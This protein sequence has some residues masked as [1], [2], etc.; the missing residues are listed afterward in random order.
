MIDAR[1]PVHEAVLIY[2]TFPETG[3][4]NRIGR[5]LVEARLAACINLIPGM[6]S[7]Y[8]WEGSIQTD[9][10]VTAIIKTTAGLA[11][12][13]AG[14]IRIAHPYTNPA[15]VVLHVAGGSRPFLDWIASETRA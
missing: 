14:F 10:E 11:N 1:L 9:T 5:A 7:I 6:Q 12:R 2:A 3:M 15:L 4:A 13:V 8:R